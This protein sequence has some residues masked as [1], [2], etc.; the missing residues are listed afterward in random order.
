[1]AQASTQV[2]GA[3]LGS[4]VPEAWGREVE[5]DVRAP[6]MGRLDMHTLQEFARLARTG[7]GFRAVARMLHAANPL[8]STM[9]SNRAM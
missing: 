8:R 5:G 2:G 4:E 3:I 7:T 6:T 9:A 1:M